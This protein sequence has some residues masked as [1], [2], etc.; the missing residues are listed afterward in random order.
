MRNSFALLLS[1]L[2]ALLAAEEIPGPSP[3]FTYEIGTDGL[4]HPC[5]NQ[6]GQT[7]LI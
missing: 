1:L 7:R 6:W 3:S 5:E 2:P 4:D